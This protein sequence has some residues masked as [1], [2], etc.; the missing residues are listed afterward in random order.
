MSI[1]RGR[2]SG[3]KTRCGGQWTEARFK[4]FIKGNLRAATRKW[5]PIQQCKKDAHRGRGQYECAECHEIVAPTI[6]DED[7][8]KRVK[9]ICVDH[10]VPVVDPDVGFTTWDE[11]IEGMFCEVEN[12]Q[13][14]CRAC[15]LVKCAEESEVAKQR[16]AKDKESNE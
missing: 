15:H 16:R 5:Q 1:Q 7:K 3:D 12:L 13:L 4:S 11:V 2:P 9:N 8:K 14:L 10:I 6:Y